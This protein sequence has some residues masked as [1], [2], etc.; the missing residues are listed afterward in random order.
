ML[1]L[2]GVEGS[3]GGIRALRDFSMSIPPGSTTALLG[4]NGAGKSTALKLMS[5]ALFPSGGEV[6]WNGRRIDGKPPEDRVRMGIALVPEGRGMFPGLTVEENL[7]VGAYTDK[8]RAKELKARLDL[9]F[10]RL[11]T[12]ARLRRSAAG[13]LSGGEQQMLTVARALMGNPK[14]LL[15][16][17]PSLGLAPKVVEELYELFGS[18]RDGVLSIVL[19]EQYVS[20]ALGLC[21]TALV[22]EN[23]EVVAQGTGAEL[24]ARDALSEA[25]LG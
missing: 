8:P 13:R 18:L 20:Y 6:F 5:G 9:A 15:L 3:Y 1:E 22:L 14:V 10:T 21:D 25:Y 4:R 17:E 23:G 19:V 2:R 12:L 7:R 11:P 24:L 16:D